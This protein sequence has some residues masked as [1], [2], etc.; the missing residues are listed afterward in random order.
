MAQAAGK[1]GWVKLSGVG[2][3]IDASTASAGH[4]GCPIRLSFDGLET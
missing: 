1:G 2:V 3:H 4:A